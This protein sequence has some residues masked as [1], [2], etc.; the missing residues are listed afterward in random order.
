[1]ARGTQNRFVV[2]LIVLAVVGLVAFGLL[3]Q[4]SSDKPPASPDAGDPLAGGGAPGRAPRSNP[5][6]GTATTATAPAP[7]ET[8]YEKPVQLP[9]EGAAGSAASAAQV[10]AAYDRAVT[11]AAGDRLV[12][13]R[14]LL[15]DALNSNA[16]PAA[17]ADDARKRL[18]ELADKTIFSRTVLPKDPCT[19]E[20]SFQPGDVLVKVERQLDLHVSERLIQRINNIPDPSRIRAGQTVK[21]VRGPFHAVVTKG[22]FLMD[23]YLQERGTGRMILVRRLRVGV[24]KDGSTPPGMWQVS[25]GR[26]MTHAPWTP[27]P[28]STLPPKRILWGEPG[29]PLGKM[30]YWI[31]L[32]GIEGNTHTAEDG[33]GIHGTNDPA[34]VGQAASLGC[35]RLTDDE[36]ELLYAMLYPKWSKVKVVK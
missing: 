32:E 11:L 15:A 26:K 9:L 7:P 29:Y 19:F 13:A 36:I 21:M 8:G 20:Y 22:R 1:M 35:I 6:A 5:P 30:G 25:L 18:I 27:P 34:S 12:E 14:G 33:F 23:V 2:T 24:G 4:R 16:L 10:R 3:R 28:S 17:A 31:G